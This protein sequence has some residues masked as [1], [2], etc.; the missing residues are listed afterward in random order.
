MKTLNLM[1]TASN[2]S[3]KIHLVSEKRFQVGFSRIW[4]PKLDP[5]FGPPRVGTRGGS[6]NGS[7][8]VQNGSHDLA[9]MRYTRTASMGFSE[10]DFLDLENTIS[11][12]GRF[13][14]LFRK[15]PKKGPKVSKSGKGGF[16]GSKK[17]SLSGYPLTPC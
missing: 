4:D 7:K 10:S 11:P 16:R 5:F 13:W 15:I 3:W 2:W 6:K 17:G 14:T 8:R 9:T 12:F 1:S